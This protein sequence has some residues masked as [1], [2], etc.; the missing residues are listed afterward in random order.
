MVKLEHLV[1][2]YVPTSCD[3]QRP[4]GE[5]IAVPSASHSVDDIRETDA[6]PIMCHI[7]VYG[8]FSFVWL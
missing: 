5:I 7:D 1:L 6:N 3:D 4:H 8:G 2:K